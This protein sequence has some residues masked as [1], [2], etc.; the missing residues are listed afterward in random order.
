MTGCSDDDG[1]DLDRDIFASSSTTTPPDREQEA[2][3]RSTFLVQQYFETRDVM[4][5]D[6]GGYLDG[7]AIEGVAESVALDEVAVRAQSLFGKKQRQTG[8]TVVSEIEV[9]DVELSATQSGTSNSPPRVQLT[10]C[11]D[12]SQVG[13]ETLDGKAASRAQAWTRREA[14][15]GVVNRSWPNIDAWRIGF[16]SVTDTPC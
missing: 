9:T 14:R 5:Q 11:I 16:V 12:Q 8:S 13:A 4:L 6:P 3:E 1:A 10:A 2:R 7:K 15:F